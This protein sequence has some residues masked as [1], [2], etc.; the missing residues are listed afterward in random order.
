MKLRRRRL[1]T[2]TY[3]P[4]GWQ[5]SP[6]AGWNP[7]L[8]AWQRDYLVDVDAAL[9]ELRWEPSARDNGH[10]L[11]TMLRQDSPAPPLA[12][13]GM[14]LSVLLYSQETL[15][16][17]KFAHHGEIAFDMLTDAIAAAAVE[18]SRQP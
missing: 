7:E 4:P 13:A 11:I 9:R 18:L 6:I 16:L 10:V 3:I 15:R 5:A 14:L 1:V 12:L 17:A 8:P 2:G